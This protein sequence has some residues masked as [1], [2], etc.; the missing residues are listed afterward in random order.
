M[1][2][3]HGK[4][5]STMEHKERDVD[6]SHT[7]ELD[8]G[9]VGGG[10]VPKGGSTAGMGTSSS[11]VDGGNRAQDAGRQEDDDATVDPMTSRAPDKANEQA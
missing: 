6:V 5:V 9:K 10:R 2:V 1:A 7:D 3:K 8:L 11:T 4:D